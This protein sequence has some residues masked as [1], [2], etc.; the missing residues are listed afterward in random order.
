MHPTGAGTVKT[1]E[2]PASSR[3]LPWHVTAMRRLARQ[4]PP[5]RYRVAWEPGL[6]APA[7]D[8]SALI[9]DHYLPVT[10]EACPAFLLRSPYGRGFPWDALYGVAFAE[11]GF[12]VVIQSCRGTGGSEGT[13]SWCHHEDA[14][15][16]AAVAWLRRQDWFNGRLGMVGPSYLGYTQWAPAKPQ[17]PLLWSAAGTTSSSIRPSPSTARFAPAGEKPACSSGPGHTPR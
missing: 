5:A 10:G 17:R 8:G 12:H 1:G 6:R 7:A 13:F 11:Q 4:L 3:W 16:Q 9:T 2:L 14:H 15:G